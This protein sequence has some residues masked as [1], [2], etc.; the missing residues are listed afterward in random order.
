MSLKNLSETAASNTSI[1][2]VNVGEGTN[3]S[4]LNNGIR[5]MAADL[6]AGL[7]G[8]VVNV[9]SAAV[10]DLGAV[11]SINVLITGNSTINA[12]AALSPGVPKRLRFQSAL[13]LTHSASLLCPGNASI[14]TLA[15]DIAEVVPEPGGIF[16]I[17]DYLRSSGLPISGGDIG[18]IGIT[19]SALGFLGNTS[20]VAAAPQ[21][22]PFYP[23]FQ[24]RLTKSGANLLLSREAGSWLFIAGVNYQVPAAGVTLGIGAAAA[25][26]SYYIYAYMSS[27][28]M[29]LEFSAT[30]PTADTIYGHQIK[31][32]DGSR[33]LVG[34]ARTSAAP[35][36]V[37]SATQRFTISQYNRKRISAQTSD[38]TQRTHGG[39]SGSEAST[40]YRTEFVTWADEEVICSISGQMTNS[41]ANQNVGAQMALDGSSFGA[42]SLH[43][44]GAGDYSGPIGLS[45][46][47]AAAVG[48]HYLTMLGYY[49]GG[50]AKYD[51]IT[52]TAVIRG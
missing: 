41:V 9:A 50:A 29:T 49:S 6:R 19:M 22:I 2:G 51:E 17:T 43:L 33:T 24:C 38:S 36:W 35:A 7:A 34:F 10:P 32:G 39:A 5:A 28:T 20:S 40:T 1:G 14:S 11:D 45:G 18:A 3:M 26:T 37:D 42:I 52:T 8:S 48:Y 31:T 15:G 25:S 30:A 23:M 21:A 16:R 47:V 44:D 12:F 13:T 4:N 46:S 27:G